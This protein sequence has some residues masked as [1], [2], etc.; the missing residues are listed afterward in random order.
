MAALP[1]AVVISGRGSNMEAIARAAQLADCP[2]RVVQV[3]ADRPTAG[4][5]A[6][7][8]ALGIPTRVVPVKDFADRSGFEAALA[9]ALDASG[10][11]LVAPAQFMSSDTGMVPAEPPRLEDTML[12]A[13]VSCA[14]YA[15]GSPDAC[16]A[17]AASVT[18]ICSH[19]GTSSSPVLFVCLARP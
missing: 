6:R 17:C 10:A 12:T 3:I 7:A 8:K 4:G 5:L 15:V 13:W 16:P 9:A 1:V 14:A 2:Y 19:P 18:L 11:Q